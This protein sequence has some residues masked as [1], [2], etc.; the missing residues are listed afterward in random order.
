MQASTARF[1]NAAVAALRKE[2]IPSSVSLSNLSLYTEEEAL[3]P[4]GAIA[5]PSPFKPL[6]RM[7]NMVSKQKKRFSEAGYD[8][9]LS[10]ITPRIISMGFPAEVRARGF[11]GNGAEWLG[12]ERR[13]VQTFRAGGILYFTMQT[14]FGS[15]NAQPCGL[16]CCFCFCQKAG[17]CFDANSSSAFGELCSTAVAIRAF[18]T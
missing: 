10:Y 9:D 11:C 2:V 13:G 1:P 5:G 8:L 7:R 17:W 12:L 16:W 15:R 3:D 6:L 14:S 18:S 4:K